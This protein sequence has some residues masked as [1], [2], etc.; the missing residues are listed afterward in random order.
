M[1]L[2]GLGYLDGVKDV[3]N[4]EQLQKLEQMGF[5][6][7]LPER[8]IDTEVMSNECNSSC[9]PVMSPLFTD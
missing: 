2:T 3:L 5:Q 1:F 4:K 8:S 9:D 7:F 6:H